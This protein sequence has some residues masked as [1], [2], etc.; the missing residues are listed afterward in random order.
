MEGADNSGQTTS[1]Q[2]TLLIGSPEP[3]PTSTSTPTST[4]TP[5]D[6]DGGGKDKDKGN[7]GQGQDKD[8][9]NQGQGGGQD[10]G[11]GNIGDFIEDVVDG[12]IDIIDNIT[13]KIAKEI[14]KAVDKA[15][16]FADKFIDDPEKTAKK[17]AKTAD[18]LLDKIGKAIKKGWLDVTPGEDTQIYGVAAA[19]IGE[20]TALIVWETNHVATSKVNYGPSPMYGGVTSSSDTSQSHTI[21]LTGLPTNTD[22]Y[23]EVISTGRTTAYDAFRVFRTLGLT[24]DGTD[25]GTDGICPEGYTF[26]PDTGSETGD[27]TLSGTCVQ[28]DDGGSIIDILLGGDGEGADPLGF[29]VEDLRLT[30]ADAGPIAQTTGAVATT[31]TTTASAVGLGAIVVTTAA[32]LKTT[33]AV[34]NSVASLGG[35]GGSGLGISAALKFLA[36]T[37]TNA[38]SNLGFIRKRKRRKEKTIGLVFDTVTGKPVNGVYLTFYSESGNLK[39]A[40][41]N[42]D[43]RYTTTLVPGNYKLSI[44]KEGYTLASREQ[45]MGISTQYPQLHSQGTDITVT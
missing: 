15:Q 8:K 11:G 45:L 39:S 10:Q 31:V 5:D 37:V 29:I 30:V 26:V 21:L 27:G 16:D 22:I 3:T 33:A 2:Y 18:S 6:G 38:L 40:I 23:F 1:T 35:V 25:P 19:S 17:L 44:H 20:T 13:D 9:G 12:V 43:G 24:D 28:D 34:Y 7:Q 42:K 36:V 4:P 32:L 41:S 14:A